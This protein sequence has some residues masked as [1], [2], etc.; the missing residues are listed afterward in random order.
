MVWIP[1][2]FNIAIKN[3]TGSDLKC[4]P[5]YPRRLN[6]VL[7]IGCGFADFYHF[8]R[9]RGFNG[10]YLGVDIVPEFVSL[11]KESIKDCPNA[12]VRAARHKF[13]SRFRL[14]LTMV[15]LRAYSITIE[16]MRINFYMKH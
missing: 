9:S 1:K 3:H 12:E 2:R 16:K 8:L 10:Q 6:S 4:L 13:L 11:A 5:V 7:D 15:S 14:G